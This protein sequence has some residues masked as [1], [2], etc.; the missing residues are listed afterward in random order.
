M[1]SVVEKVP[2]V[3]KLLAQNGFAC[4]EPK[5]A[6]GYQDEERLLNCTGVDTAA[7]QRKSVGKGQLFSITKKAVTIVKEIHKSLGHAGWKC[8][9]KKGLF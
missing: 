9:V 1:Q 8:I 6:I 5:Q 2:L 4:K 3:I 7:L